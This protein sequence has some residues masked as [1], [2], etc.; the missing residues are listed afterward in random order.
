MGWGLRAASRANLKD[1][2]GSMQ[3]SGS[4]EHSQQSP[5]SIW[6]EQGEEVEAREVVGPS[7]ERPLRL[8]QV[9]TQILYVNSDPP[10]AA[11][12]KDGVEA[13]DHG[14]QAGTGVRERGVKDDT[15]ISDPCGLVWCHTPVI[16]ATDQ[17]SVSKDKPKYCEA[18]CWLHR[19][20]PPVS[21]QGAS[22]S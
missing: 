21:P 22:R 5:A 3:I 8:S 4:G 7:P 10:A 14:R 2:R 20:G 9:A 18:S 12:R 15:K 6:E 16:P 13:G 11:W 1:G 17:D 19:S